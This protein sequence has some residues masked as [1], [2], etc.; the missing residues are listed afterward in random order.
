MHHRLT[1]EHPVKRV[2]MQQRKP[3]QMES[4]FFVQRQRLNTVLFLAFSSFVEIVDKT[5]L[6]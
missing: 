6:I 1:D 3:G 2:L 5:A 4:R